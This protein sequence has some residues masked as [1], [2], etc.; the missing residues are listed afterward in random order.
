MGCRAV[1]FSIVGC[2]AVGFSIVGCRAVGFS[3][4][5][6]RAVGCRA[7][8]C[9]V[10]GP[11][12]IPRSSIKASDNFGICLSPLRVLLNTYIVRQYSLATTDYILRP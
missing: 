9:R 5:G 8:V 6:C 10:V 11:P 3:I 1:G 12:M 7:S 4:V 2:R